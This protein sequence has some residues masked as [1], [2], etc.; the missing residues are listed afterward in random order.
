MVIRTD[1][2]LLLYVSV[3]CV[4]L[5]NSETDGSGD[6]YLKLCCV[7]LPACFR[8]RNMSQQIKI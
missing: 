5:G 7:E 6:D 4:S 3:H 1:V 2:Y 8:I